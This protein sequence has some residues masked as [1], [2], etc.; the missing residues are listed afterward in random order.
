MRD[1]PLTRDNSAQCKQALK[2]RAVSPIY[3][4]K[5]IPWKA[6]EREKSE[7]NRLAACGKAACR[8]QKRDFSQTTVR[9]CAPDGMDQ[10][11]K[12]PTILV[13]RVR[14]AFGQHQWRRHFEHFSSMRRLL[15]LYCQ[16]IRFEHQWI[17]HK[18][19]ADFHIRRRLIESPRSWCWPKEKR[20]LVTKS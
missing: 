11:D 19:I 7:R 4:L 10:S 20:P 15:I 2:L 8:K 12:V 6:C 9:L 3:A 5:S 16:P 17:K 14:F 18:W 13:L 1:N